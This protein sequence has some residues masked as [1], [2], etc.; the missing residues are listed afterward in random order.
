[1]A[2]N[3][4][5]M[6]A[7]LQQR[8]FAIA[9]SCSYTQ[10][11]RSHGL[12]MNTW[13]E[14]LSGTLASATLAAVVACGTFDA[15]AGGS[16]QAGTTPAALYQSYCSVC[17]GDQG[18]GQSRA[19]A[20]LNP[21]PTDFTSPVV[22][23]SMPRERMIVSVRE[24][25]PGTA[26]VGWKTQLTDT[27]IATTVDFIRSKF[28]D[29]VTQQTKP[30]TTPALPAASSKAVTTS[31]SLAP[32]D[33]ALKGNFASGRPL[34]EQ[35]CVACHGAAGDGKGPRAAVIVPKPRSFVSV[36]SRAAFS[37]P[38]L[39]LSITQGKRGTGMPAWEKVLSPQEI[40]DV[41]EYVFQRFISPS[42]NS[43][44]PNQK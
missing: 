16:S 19:R 41:A 29:P 44:P 9:L 14:R 34:Y 6:H 24:G 33:P 25:R 42:S 37:R 11:I 28:M 30:G 31:A 15:V 32:K 20:S 2:L 1:M 3:L 4:H 35:N 23:A 27:Q 18:N 8:L 7:D 40:A 21:P 39:V 17:H 10:A 5:V 43:S 13:I 22:R 36:E 12:N 38:V 26:M